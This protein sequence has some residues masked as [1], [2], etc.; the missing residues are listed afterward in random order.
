MIKELELTHLH[1]K[2]K[3]SNPC[4]FVTVGVIFINHGDNMDIF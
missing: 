1:T 2:N 3:E 4:T